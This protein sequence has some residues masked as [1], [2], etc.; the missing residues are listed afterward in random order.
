MV[1]V[2]NRTD[3]S[4]GYEYGGVFKDPELTFHQVKQDAEDTFE[5]KGLKQLKKNVLKF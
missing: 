3:R 5:G 2:T 4:Y 1:W